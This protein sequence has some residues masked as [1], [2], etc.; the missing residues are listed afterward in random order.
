M[1]VFCEC[2]LRPGAHCG[3]DN[4]MDVNNFGV[5]RLA[6]GERR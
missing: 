4:Q 6:R 5:C 2:T 1:E 3:E